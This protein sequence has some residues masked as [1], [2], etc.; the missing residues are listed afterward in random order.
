[1][2]RL[3]LNGVD[4][5]AAAGGG[6]AIPLSFVCAQVAECALKA[7]LSKNGDDRRLRDKALRHNLGALWVLAHSEGLPIPATPPEWIEK[8]S[9][10]HDTPYYIRFSTGAHGLVTPAPAEMQTGLRNL[11]GV[12]E[13][14]VH[15]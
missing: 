1:M 10:L 9:Q 12:A 13:Q 7:S 6:C 5:L 15:S 14:H 2:A 3:L 8:L 11:V 4:P